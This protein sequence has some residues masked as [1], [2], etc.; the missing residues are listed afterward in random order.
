MVRF[1]PT[2]R[3]GV[4]HIETAL[5]LH[6]ASIWSRL[7][8][9]D[10]VVNAGSDGAHRAGSLH[11]WDLALDLDTEGDRPDDIEQLHGYLARILPFEFDVVLEVD[12]VHV[13]YDPHRKPLPLEPRFR[14]PATAA[15]EK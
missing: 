5:V 12:H 13:E 6:H 9:I 4:L 8:G 14:Q 11:P 2:F 10:L 1:E 7:A 15:A 3:L